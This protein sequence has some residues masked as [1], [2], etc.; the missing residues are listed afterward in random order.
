MV[1]WPFDQHQ[2]TIR[3]CAIWGR[4][5]IYWILNLF[6]S[7]C[8]LRAIDFSRLTENPYKKIGGNK[9]RVMMLHRKLPSENRAKWMIVNYTSIQTNLKGVNC[10]ICTSF[11]S[12]DDGEWT[13]DKETKDFTIIFK[14]LG[15]ITI[16]LIFNCIFAPEKA[17]IDSIKQ[18]WTTSAEGPDQ[19]FW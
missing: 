10:P 14:I 15:I 16:L 18:S 1:E 2:N 17:Q 8:R 4:A 12:T 19:S 13:E 7:K 9:L 6:P 5:Y 11:G 3:P